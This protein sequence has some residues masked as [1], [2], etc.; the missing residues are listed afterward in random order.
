MTSISSP[1]GRFLAV[2]LVLIMLGGVAP[3]QTNVSVESVEAESLEEPTVQMNSASSCPTCQSYNLYLDEPNSES[4]GE[5]SITTLEPTGAHQEASAFGGVEFRSAEMISDLLVYGRDNTDKVTLTLFLQFK[6]SQGSTAD[7]TYSLKSGDSEV[8]SVSETLDDPCTG[9]TFGTSSCSWTSSIVDFEVPSDGFTVANGKQLRLNVDAQATCESSSGGGLGGGSCEVNVAFGDVEQTNGYS[10][11]EMKANAL[12]N[13]VVKVHRP[14]GGFLEPEVTEWSPAHRPEFRNMQ[15]SVDVRDAFGRDD[16]QGVDLVMTTPNE[17]GT[18]FSKSFDD[19]DLKLDNNGLVGNYTFQYETGIAAGEY[20]LRLEISDVQG[21]TLVFEHSGIEFVEHDV[22]LTL[23]ES[24]PDVILIAPGQTSSVEFLIEH[25]GASSS[26]LDVVFSL[27]RS[28][29]STWSDPVW[30]QPGGYSLSGGGTFARPILSI[31]VPDDDLTS[32]PN[33]LEIEARAYAE[34]T[35]GQTVEVA[36]ETIVLDVEESDVLSPPRIAVFEDDEHQKQIA[37]S[38]RPEAY[39]ELLSHYVDSGDVSGDFFIDVFNS[40][41]IT[42]AFK[43]RVTELPDAWQY[44]F[45]DN[46]TGLELVEEGIH[47]VT[48]DIGSHQILTVRMEVFPPSERDAQDIGLVSISIASQGDSE[49]STSVAFTVHRTFGVLV[50]VTADSDS[51][52]L[53]T[54][55]P[56]SPGSSLWYQMRITDSSDTI[57]QTT[58]RIINPE[59][60]DRNN[61]DDA[62]YGSWNYE[63][64][65]GS[66]SDI[67]VVYL[68]SDQYADLKLDVTIGDKVEAGNHTV[69]VRVVEEGVDAQDA[70]YFDLPVTVQVREDVQ[71]GR[72]EITDTS[73]SVVRFNSGEFQTVEYSIDNQN[74]IPLDVVITLEN[75]PQGWDVLVRASSDQTGGSFLLLTLPAYSSKDFSLAI[76]PPN[77]LKNGETVQ[78]ELKVTPM[79]EEVPYD[80]E[81]TQTSKQIYQTSCQGAGC[82]VNELVNPEPQTLALGLGLCAAFV[83]AVYRRGQ[84]SGTMY[85]EEIFEYEDE[86]ELEPLESDLPDPVLEEED[87]DDLEL[88]DELEAL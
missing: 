53:G 6:G 26:Q 79:D 86:K 41:F 65:N 75:E 22:Y 17:A 69:Y 3:L 76:T 37:D 19:D 66:Q 25:T 54:V 33:T 49:L 78:F 45:Y 47:S 21:H 39:D 16:I 84:A 42:D 40:G 56:V 64:S 23:P 38:T 70:R 85:E 13:S 81:Y 74:N 61:E 46:D 58:W 15:F 50:E 30:D 62:P 28:L 31:E 57:G 10:K 88:L 9:G 73:S 44:K 5:G 34:N 27:S 7:I 72:L 43:L 52:T 87:D 63:I 68:E 51:G 48:P 80:S 4:G 18:V 11:L 83:F 24:Q 29:P 59:D 8:D 35:E 77:N 82:F 55:G 67:V 12:A 60:L 2:L 20:P 32:A 71:P 36:V 14:G 1:N